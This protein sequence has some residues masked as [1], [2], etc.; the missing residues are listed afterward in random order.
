MRT[1]TKMPTLGGAWAARTVF[2]DQFEIQDKLADSISAQTG[3]TA[4]IIA[5]GEIHRLDHPAVRRGNKRIWYAC[6]LDFAVW[7]DWATSEQ[8]AIFADSNPAPET[9]KRAREEAERRKRERQAELERG[10][11]LVARQCRQEWPRLFAADPNHPYLKAKGI[12]PLTLRQEGKLLVVPMYCEAGLVNYQTIAPDGAK[13]FRTGGRKK[14]AYWPVGGLKVGEPLLVCEGVA[15]GI[16]LYM[17]TGNAVAC[18]MDCG[19]L[20]PVARSLRA[21]H[22]GINIVICADNDHQTDGNPG[23]TAGKAAAAAVGGRC[24]WPEF[25]EGAEGTDFNDLAA[26]GGEV[27]V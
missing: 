26:I 18:A 10:R 24:I 16:T 17:V 25:P 12:K 6:H 4:V 7:G 21:R 19:N 11:A 9:A 13:R 14:G 8:H 5:D 2:S 27:V 22:P 1:E 15:T 23:I 20:L 3:L